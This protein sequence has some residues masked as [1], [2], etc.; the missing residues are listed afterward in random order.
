LS[1]N[2]KII[3]LA[4]VCLILTFTL[5]GCT[6]Q[7]RPE[8]TPAPGPTPIPQQNVP[9]QNQEQIPT[10]PTELNKLAQ[11]LAKEAA[12]VNGVKDATV[13]ITGNTALVGLDL[14]ANTPTQQINS[15]QEQVANTIKQADQRIKNVSV[16]AD[17]DLTTRIRNI[18]Q[19]IAN[20]KPI[21]GF[22]QEIDDLIKRI[23]PTMNTR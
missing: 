11:N 6:A 10:D 2:R 19:E 23:G 16:T 22:A 20:G 4:I 3:I 8:Q 5:L 9:P 15:I 14:A 7:R 18:G 17:A 1:K 21:S 12:K 13:V